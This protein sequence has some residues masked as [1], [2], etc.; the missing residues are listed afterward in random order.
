MLTRFNHLCSFVS[1]SA[2]LALSACTLSTKLADLAEDGSAEG[3]GASGTSGGDEASS[4]PTTGDPPTGGG[5]GDTSPF[6][7]GDTG[8][9]GDTGGI[10]C[11]DVQVVGTPLSPNVVLVLDKSGSMVAG[12]GGFWDH[13]ADPGTPSVTRWSSLHSVV[14]SIVTEFDDSINFGAHLFPS[15]D[16]QAAYSPAACPVHGTLDIAVAAMN[17]DAVL[18]GIPEASD[19][20]LRGGTPTANA[21]KVALDHLKDLDPE[22]PRAILLVTDGAA[23]CAVDDSPPA[24]FEEYDDSVHSIVEDAFTIDGIPTYVVGIGIVDAASPVAAD[25]SPDDTNPFDRLND[26]AT[27]GGKPR[28]DPAERFYHTNNQIELAAAL[29]EIAVD[30]L[31]CIIPLQSALVKP[32]TTGVE[33]DGELVPQVSDCASENGW[34]YTNPEGPF[35]AIQ[36]CGSACGGLKIVGSADLTVCVPD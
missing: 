4:A 3:D 13:D 10:S 1:L 2:A 29:D 20:T 34:V 12:Q 27:E 5:G 36:L 22:V 32:E 33:L 25:G 21:V 7:T 11:S 30:A 23:N 16:A 28:S 35:D 19:E 15:T 8:D 26:L 14:E 17:K 31:T 9:G 18:A 24:L 6:N